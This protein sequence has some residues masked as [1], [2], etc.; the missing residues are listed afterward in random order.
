M[1]GETESK[2]PASGEGDARV[3]R[4]ERVISGLLRVGV[5]VSLFVVTL[6]TATSFV[7]HPDYSRSRQN[8]S[9]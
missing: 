8:F 2:S 3:R 4:V 6:G 7:H 5:V 1:T 9:G